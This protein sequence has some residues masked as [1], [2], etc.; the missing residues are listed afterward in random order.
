MIEWI[1][2]LVLICV[3]VF[4]VYWRVN[5]GNVKLNIANNLRVGKRVP[6]TKDKMEVIEGIYYGLFFYWVEKLN[7]IIHYTNMR[8]YVFVDNLPLL[9][10]TEEE[11]IYCLLIKKGV[12]SK[13]KPFFKTYIVTGG[14]YKEID[15]SKY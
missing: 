5:D 15:I 3:Y 9:K 12:V 1:L 4:Y 2:F 6:I 13:K 8:Y 11:I 10:N 7:E 14:L